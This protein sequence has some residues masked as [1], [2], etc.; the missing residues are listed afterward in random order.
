LGFSGNPVRE[1]EAGRRHPTAAQALRLAEVMSRDLGAIFRRFHEPSAVVVADAKVIEAGALGKWLRVL[2]GATQIK[3]IESRS[4]LSRFSIGRML[5]GDSSLRFPEFLELVHAVTLRG[6]DLISELVDAEQVPALPI[7]YS[8]KA[9]R[10]VGLEHPWVHAFLRLIET[11]EFQ[12]LSSYTPSWFAD[13]LRIEP[14][15][16]EEILNR[17]IATG[18][19]TTENGTLIAHHPKVLYLGSHSDE[20]VRNKRHYTSVVE[21]RLADGLTPEDFVLSNVISVSKSSYE[22]IRAILQDAARKIRAIT[23]DTPEES[24]A[25]V[26]GL[27]VVQ[28]GK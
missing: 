24:V 11:K 12:Q 9:L 10:E 3:V 5:R 26:V 17:M 16:A 21:Q 23:R 14:R 4:N 6:D 18:V 7:D 25:A 22:E 19:L 2:R 27:H 20:A 8:R 13:R 1:W 28:W 15:L